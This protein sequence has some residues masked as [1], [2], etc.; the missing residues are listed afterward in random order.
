MV[1]KLDGPLFDRKSPPVPSLIACL[2]LV[3]PVIIRETTTLS[4]PEP[5][6]HGRCRGA[7]TPVL[8]DHGD[9]GGW[10]SGWGRLAGWTAIAGFCFRGGR[11][12]RLGPL[13]DF[14]QMLLHSI[15]FREFSF[16]L[17]FLLHE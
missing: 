16:F 2:V 17:F 1:K 12:K 6:S 4:Y 8:E 15:Q 14:L 5:S 3:A 11:S 7:G 13:P 10:G 9:G